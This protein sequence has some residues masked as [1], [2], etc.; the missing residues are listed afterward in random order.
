MFHSNTTVICNIYV[1]RKLPT[2]HTMVPTVTT[3]CTAE[4]SVLEQYV[5]SI[6][7]IYLQTE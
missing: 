4:Y 7:R 3:A 5:A 1:G 2:I 6:F